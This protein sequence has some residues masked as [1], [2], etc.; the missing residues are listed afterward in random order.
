MA[1]FAKVSKFPKVI[2]PVCGRHSVIVEFSPSFKISD[3]DTGEFKQ[4]GG[5]DILYKDVTFYDMTEQRQFH[6]VMSDGQLHYLLA[7]FAYSID[8][9]EGKTESEIEKFLAETP[10]DL[11]VTKHPQFGYQFSGREPKKAQS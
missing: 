7:S 10:V 4:K 9:L 11:Y 6:K 8:A 5:V 1:T 2:T 3:P